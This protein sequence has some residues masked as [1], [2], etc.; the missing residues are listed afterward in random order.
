MMKRYL[1]GTAGLLVL[2]LLGGCG[3][4]SLQ[5]LDEDVSAPVAQWGSGSVSD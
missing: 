3:Y 2:S 5:A 1:I 4:N